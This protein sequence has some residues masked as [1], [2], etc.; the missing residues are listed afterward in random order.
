MKILFDGVKVNGR[1]L[2]LRL[3][4]ELRNVTRRINLMKLFLKQ[5]HPILKELIFHQ[6]LELFLRIQ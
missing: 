6:L 3:Q 5:N 1:R 4:E 2:K